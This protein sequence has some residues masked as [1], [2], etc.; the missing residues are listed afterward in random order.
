MNAE[1][2]LKHRRKPQTKNPRIEIRGF[3][4]FFSEAISSAT[5]LPCPTGG[6]LHLGAHA[7]LGCNGESEETRL[8]FRATPQ[9]DTKPAL[10]GRG[11]DD[12]ERAAVETVIAILPQLDLEPSIGPDRISDR[13]R[14]SII[15]L[16][17]FQLC[18]SPRV[19]SI[20][21]RHHRRG[22]RTADHK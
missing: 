19:F 12:A 10:D 8:L 5:A 3:L 14:Y 9:R 22:Q 11:P 17:L 7:D 4:F 21:D 2:M 13:R 6:E 1:Q 18:L 16:F 20:V 15:E